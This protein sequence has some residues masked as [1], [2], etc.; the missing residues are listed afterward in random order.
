M[1]NT[2][3][4]FIFIMTINVLLWFGQVAITELGDT[5]TNFYNC[6]GTMLDS[7]GDCENYQLTE[8]PA[9]FLPSSEGTLTTGDTSEFTDVINNVKSWFTSIDKGLDFLWSMVLAPFNLL[10]A[11][12]LPTEIAFGLGVFWYGITIFLIISFI[13][14]RE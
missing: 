4:A 13:W 5:S 8:N 9:G 2:T 6:N 11:M 12:L 10:K 1:T 14:G 7:F 3:T